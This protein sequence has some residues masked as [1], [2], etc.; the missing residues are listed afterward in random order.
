MKSRRVIPTRLLESGFRFRYSVWSE[1]AKDL[2][3]RWKIGK[4]GV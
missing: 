1:A 4:R 3:G 2:C